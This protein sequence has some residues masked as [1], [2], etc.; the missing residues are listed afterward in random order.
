MVEKDKITQVDDIPAA[1]TYRSRSHWY[2]GYFVLSVVNIVTIAAGILLNDNMV[3]QYEK[4]NEQNRYWSEHLS[5]YGEL[6]ILLAGANA[7]GNDVFASRDPRAESARLDAALNALNKQLAGMR[8][9]HVSYPLA[10]HS[11]EWLGL[12]DEVE[13]L[14]AKMN[15]QT[16][17]LLALF[18]AGELA[19]AGWSMA[20][21]DRTHA[22]VI[23]IVNHLE[24]EAQELQRVS[25]GKQFQL[26]E[27]MRNI[28]RF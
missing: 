18:A 3:R 8:D 1:P 21:M 12:I 2:A 9:R 10:I 6:E 5:A 16:R 20:R 4:L 27:Q 13:E 11:N 24:K 25:L 26:A 7:P 15:R 19:D 28:E 17:D 14:V 22:E 23:V